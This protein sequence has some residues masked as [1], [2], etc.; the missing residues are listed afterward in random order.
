MNKVSLAFASALVLASSIVY[1]TCGPAYNPGGGTCVLSATG[2]TC[3]QTPYQPGYC[4]GGGT[5]NC[6]TTPT[7]EPVL[8]CTL[9]D[10]ATC[11]AS[12]ASPPT[13]L[14]VPIAT[15]DTGNCGA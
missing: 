15:D 13:N 9:V 8:T 11:S 7:P 6:H 10:V 3:Y 5:G 1:A 14:N 4:G 2:K 12:P